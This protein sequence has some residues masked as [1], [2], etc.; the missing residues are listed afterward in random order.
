MHVDA[1][2]CAMKIGIDRLLTL[3]ACVIGLMFLTVG[4]RNVSEGDYGWAAF[5]VACAL[6]GFLAVHWA[7]RHEH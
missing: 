3:L 1:M 5:N 2:L 6:P 7:A 4:I